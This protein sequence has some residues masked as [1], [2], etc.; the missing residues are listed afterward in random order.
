MER[1]N[2]LKNAGVA[3][4][5]LVGSMLVPK[6]ES[7]EIIP[8][9]ILKQSDFDTY[10]P[11]REKL[12]ER[13]KGIIISTE[14]IDRILNTDISINEAAMLKYD[15]KKSWHYTP[16]IMSYDFINCL[17]KRAILYCLFNDGS[18][19]ILCCSKYRQTQAIFDEIEQIW[20]NA[21][22]LRE[23]CD[24]NS[25]IT[26]INYYIDQCKM[27]LNNRWIMARTIGNNEEKIR[28]LVSGPYFTPDNI[29]QIHKQNAIGILINNA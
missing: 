15:L 11:S 20:D 8:K 4:I 3:S 22:V 29:E 17:A 27:R 24:K 5:G 21:P 13:T 26:R 1:R 6:A 28:G 14:E 18:K 16:Y 12:I 23:L 10:R 7:K 9:N 25:S 19:I 2:F